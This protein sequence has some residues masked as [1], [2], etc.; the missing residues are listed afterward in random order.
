M[1]GNVTKGRKS[2]GALI[3]RNRVGFLGHYVGNGVHKSFAVLDG[4]VGVL[5]LGRRCCDGCFFCDRCV[6]LRLVLTP[7][8]SN[9]EGGAR[10]RGGW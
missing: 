3:L 7:S 1:G 4:N 10:L 8:G 5:F 6:M 2:E 9:R